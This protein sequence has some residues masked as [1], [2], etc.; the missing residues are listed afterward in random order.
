[1]SLSPVCS[2]NTSD[3]A[4]HL[5]V[6]FKK[7]LTSGCKDS[8]LKFL[9][10]Q[11]QINGFIPSFTYTINKCISLES[12]K[13][14]LVLHGSNIFLYTITLSSICPVVSMSDNIRSWKKAIPA[15]HYWLLLNFYHFKCPLVS[16]WRTH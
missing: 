2:C 4:T 7:F 1:M 9:Q 14:F 5:N 15:L 12:H 11:T 8:V 16:L 6:Y 10:E 13:F 3:C